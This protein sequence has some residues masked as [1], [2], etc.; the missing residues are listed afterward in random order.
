MK[1]IKNTMLEMI[2]HCD[3]SRTFEACPN[4]PKHFI[5]LTEEQKEILCNWIDLNLTRIKDVNNRTLD[6][7]GLKGRFERSPGGFYILNGAFKGAMVHMGYKHS[8]GINWYFNIKK[9]K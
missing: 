1:K 4:C 2:S 8:K 7:Y 3:C 5:D 6:S 9:V